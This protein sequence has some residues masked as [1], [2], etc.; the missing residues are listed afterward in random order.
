MDN[1]NKDTN[2]II[3]G[4]NETMNALKNLQIE[5]LILYE[6]LEYQIVDLIPDGKGKED[7]IQKYLKLKDIIH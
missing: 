4:V 1:I 3:F 7:Q 2:L 5:T 6:N